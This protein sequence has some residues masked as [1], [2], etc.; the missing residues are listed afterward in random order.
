VQLSKSFRATIK[1]MSES[2]NLDSEASSELKKFA[3]GVE[4][5]ERENYM[6]QRRIHALNIVNLLTPMLTRVKEQDDVN[7]M[8]QRILQAAIK[9]S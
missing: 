8:L 5:L 3:S 9:L 6:R 7:G 1:K 4:K 2:G